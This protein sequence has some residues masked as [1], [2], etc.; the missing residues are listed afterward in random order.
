MGISAP[1]AGMVPNGKPMIVPRIHGFH[2]RFQS[3]HFI[4]ME[5]LICSSFS[6]TWFIFEAK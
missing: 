1:P 2:E 6:S 5:P 3:S 4:Q